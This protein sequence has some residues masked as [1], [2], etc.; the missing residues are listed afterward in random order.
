MLI[1]V[2]DCSLLL[3]AVFAVVGGGDVVGG[4]G[5]IV[6]VGVSVLVGGSVAGGVVVFSIYRASVV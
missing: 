3:I 6:G 5:V 2:N 1:A 4:V